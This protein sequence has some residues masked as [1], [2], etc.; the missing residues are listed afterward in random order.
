M[1]HIISALQSEP[2][3]HNKTQSGPEFSSSDNYWLILAQRTKHHVDVDTA[4]G[5]FL[6]Y[7]RVVG[8]DDVMC[9]C[10]GEQSNEVALCVNVFVFCSV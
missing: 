2:C 7:I 1:L 9:V 3:S 10:F 6:F 5:E 4:D 8:K